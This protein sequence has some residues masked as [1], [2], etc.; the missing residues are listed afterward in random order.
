MKSIA[1]F[2]NKGGVGKTTLTYHLGYALAELGYKTLLV[3]LDPQSNLTLF[4]LN[5]EKLHN[6]WQEEDAFI[7]DFVDARYQQSVGFEDIASD[8]RSIHFILKPTEDGTDPPEPLAKPLK[9]HDNLGM[10]PGRLS[11]HTYGD[12]IASRWTDVYGGDLLAIQTVTQIRHFCKAYAE[13]Y[14]YD[15]V[16]I[17]T[18]PSFG[19]LNKVIISTVDGLLIP[20]MPDMFTL[21]GIQHIGKSLKEWK[22]DF[23]TIFNLLSDAK[24]SYFPKNFASFLGFTIFNA[25]RY[26]RS[27]AHHNYA[28]QIPATI[29]KYI[30]A[31]HRK[32]LTEA[33]LEDPIGGTAIMPSYPSILP[34]V[35]Q[36]YR[37]PMWK[38][39]SCEDLEKED[40]I[41]ILRNRE[42]YE[43]TQTGFHI[44]AK[45]LL[46]R[47]DRLEVD[48]G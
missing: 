26:S 22:R 48:N 43:N 7:D 12:K 36:K 44:F 6:I 2:N 16:V 5:P 27:R 21:Y 34:S 31:D 41:T 18:S 35:A 14:A 45:D 32:H 19:I 25:N 46:T 24:L 13:K 10:I 29:K 11:I 15:Y 40:K 39:P 8:I 9:L 38:V 3:D 47:L 1:V 30:D 4:G 23:D 28:K 17:D 33:Q 37:T 42:S 20:C